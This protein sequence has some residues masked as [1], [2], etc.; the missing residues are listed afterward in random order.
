MLSQKKQ[1]KH[2]YIFSFLMFFLLSLYITTKND[3]LVLQK[4]LEQYGTIWG[5]A[6]FFSKNW[7]GRI[8]PLGVL[9]LL[10]QIPD[11]AFAFIN[12]IMWGVLIEHVIKIFDFERKK[13]GIY[14]MAVIVTSVFVFI[15]D[16]VLAYSV[17]WKCANVIYLWGTACSFLVI[18]VCM[19]VVSGRK[20]PKQYYVFAVI[21]M[22]FASS[23]E[24]I[25]VFMSFIVLVLWIYDVLTKKKAN[26]LFLCFVIVT[27]ALSAFFICLP[28]NALR[29]VYSI[30]SYYPGYNMYSL[31]DRLYLGLNYTI[32]GLEENIPLLLT[33]LSGLLLYANKRHGENRLL[34]IVSAVIFAFFALNAV[35]RIGTLYDGQKYLLGRLFE[36]YSVE[37]TEFF[38][39][40][41]M[42]IKELINVF[43][44]VLLGCEMLVYKHD[45]TGL[46]AFLVYVGG[47]GT[48]VMMG[49]SPTVHASGLR[50]MF[51]GCFCCIC[52]LVEVLSDLPNGSVR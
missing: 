42:I 7:G 33:V 14:L 20:L 31:F 43:A 45:L 4:G 27:V 9:V 36:F 21:S 46:M 24:Q 28:G 2:I 32:T 5:W 11:Y 13:N 12:A 22:F 40:I 38:I 39:S 29:S 35:H 18:Y 19:C 16:D 37:T 1:S 49:F 8:V 48:M 34:V 25:A 17:F 6:N 23:Y 3:D 26:W 52:L 50:P 10:L 44:F 51:V 47:I 30:I 41:S 15:P